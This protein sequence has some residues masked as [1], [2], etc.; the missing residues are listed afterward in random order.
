MGL[1]SK[2]SPRPQTNRSGGRGT[3]A[4]YRDFSKAP[5]THIVYTWPWSTYIRTLVAG[6]SCRLSAVNLL[7]RVDTMSGKLEASR[8]PRKLEKSNQPMRGSF[9]QPFNHW[10]QDHIKL[11]GL[12]LVRLPACELTVTMAFR[13]PNPVL[14]IMLM[15]RPRATWQRARTSLGGGAPSFSDVVA[16]ILRLNKHTSNARVVLLLGLG[17]WWTKHWPPKLPETNIKDHQIN[18]KHIQALAAKHLNTDSFKAISLWKGY[19]DVLWTF[20]ESGLGSLGLLVC[21]LIYYSVS[22]ASSPK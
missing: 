1:G 21:P 12:Q 15:H 16:Q 6:V 14:T 18:C 19:V 13:K 5:C 9:S 11:N 17:A 8:P 10:R 3:L 20:L 22:K 7:H 4:N 2:V